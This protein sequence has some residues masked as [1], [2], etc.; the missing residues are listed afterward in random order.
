M[1]RNAKEQKVKMY[2]P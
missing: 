2:S 1:S